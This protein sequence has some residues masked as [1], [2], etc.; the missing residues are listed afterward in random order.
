[1]QARSGS[2]RPWNRVS[3]ALAG[4]LRGRRGSNEGILTTMSGLRRSIGLAFGVWAL[5][6][7]GMAHAQENLDAGKTAAEL[8]ASDCAIC[9]KSPHG[10][11]NKVGGILGLQSF[12]QEH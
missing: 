6:G 2:Q 12:L 3:V 8:Y 9:H 5:A 1:M 11:S 7:L 10:L 4:A